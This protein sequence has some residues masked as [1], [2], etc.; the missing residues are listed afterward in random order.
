M[1]TREKKT[2]ADQGEQ[3]LAAFGSSPF[4]GVFSFHST[5]NFLIIEYQ[6]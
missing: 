1:N 2:G 6:Q 4:V 5:L 3:V